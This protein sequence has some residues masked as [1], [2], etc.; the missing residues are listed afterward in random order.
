MS[1]RKLKNMFEEYNHKYFDK[2]LINDLEFSYLARRFHDLDMEVRNLDDNSSHPLRE[3]LKKER[4]K[5]KDEAY[6][7]LLKFKDETKAK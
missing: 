6:T 3:K 2:L 4:M 7:I 5:V 1:H